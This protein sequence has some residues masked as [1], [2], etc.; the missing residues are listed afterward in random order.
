MIAS[1]VLGSIIISMA[2]VALFIAI[3]MGENTVSK[4][5]NYPLTKVEKSYVLNISSYDYDDLDNLEL[6]VERLKP[7]KK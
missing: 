6:D 5:G 1:S 4:A 7:P 3:K 2:T